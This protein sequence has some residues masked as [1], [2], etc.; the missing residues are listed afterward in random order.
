MSEYEISTAEAIE[1]ER[2]RNNYKADFLWPHEIGSAEEAGYEF[3]NASTEIYRK[4]WWDILLDRA[5]QH[6]AEASRAND[7]EA[8]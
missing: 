2:H 8:Q 7:K 5:R 3:A 6:N 4:E 1:L